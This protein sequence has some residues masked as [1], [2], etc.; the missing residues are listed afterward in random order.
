MTRG[1][2]PHKKYKNNISLFDSRLKY[3]FLFKLTLRRKMM[4]DRLAIYLHLA[5]RKTA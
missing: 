1:A 2:A 3:L 4:D 5:I